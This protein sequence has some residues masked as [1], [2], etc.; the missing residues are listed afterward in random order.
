MNEE[1]NP[2]SWAD[3][4]YVAN[5]AANILERLAEENEFTRLQNKPTIEASLTLLREMLLDHYGL[6]KSPLLET[7]GKIAPRKDNYPDRDFERPVREAP[8][9]SNQIRRYRLAR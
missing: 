4:Q 6:T 9:Q 2:D 7:A 3:Q 1:Q 8:P 5:E